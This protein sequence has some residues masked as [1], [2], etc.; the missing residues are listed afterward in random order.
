MRPLRR[1]GGLGIPSGSAVKA[2]L[3]LIVTCAVI[4]GHRRAAGRPQAQVGDINRPCGAGADVGEVVAIHVN[5]LKIR[6][7]LRGQRVGA[8]GLR[9]EDG[10]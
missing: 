2:V 10:G 8:C 1:G 5:I 3:V 4:D 7:L 6:A 9:C